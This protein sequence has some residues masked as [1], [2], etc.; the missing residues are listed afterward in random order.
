MDEVTIL[1]TKPFCN[2]SKPLLSLRVGTLKH[3]HIVQVFDVF[4]TDSSLYV[5]LDLAT[6]GDLFDQI[7]SVF[8]FF[9]L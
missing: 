7:V 8:E 6:G 1:S 4:E 5:V 3:S 2:S 9:S